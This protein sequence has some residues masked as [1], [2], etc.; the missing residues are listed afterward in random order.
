MTNMVHDRSCEVRFRRAV[1]LF[2]MM[3]LLLS[4]LL[5][6]G[7]KSLRKVVRIAY[8]EFNRQMI[9]DEHN[10]P[11]SGYAYDYIQTIGTYAGWKVQFIPCS[12]F[13]DSV[14]LLLADKVDL[15]YEISYTE[16]R[17]REI[18][19]PNEPM[20]YEHY[21]L[22]S[23]VDNTSITPGDYASMDGKT[24]G[25]TTGTILAGLL[26]EWCKQKKI[27]FKLVE[28]EDIS[29]KEADLYAGKIDLDLELS[30][31]AKRNLSAVEKVGASAYYLV[32]GKKRPDL[33]K[34]INSA[35]DKILSNDPF[36]FSRLQERYF[37]DTVLSRNLTAEE[38][39]GL[40][41]IGLCGSGSS[42]NISRFPRKMKT[43][44]RSAPASKPSAKS[45][46]R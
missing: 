27:N 33:I 10:H 13:F 16:E 41:N 1:M 15:I 39:N 23:S 6:G 3:L 38:K 5:C 32:A 43:A 36:Y 28:Y 29:K 24:V 40:R 14:R 46:M 9:V 31:L 25:V 45:S 8:Q 30:M 12:S 42:T 4:G 17:A 21:Y 18:L 19:F 20:G 44:S 22:Y 2:G 34:D 11:V 7:E 37:S 35:M 26:K